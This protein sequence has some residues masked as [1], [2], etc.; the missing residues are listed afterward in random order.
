MSGD[1]YVGYK[2]GAPIAASTSDITLISDKVTLLDTDRLQ[3]RHT[4]REALHRR[5]NH[6]HRRRGGTLQLTANNFS[7]NFTDD[8]SSITVGSATTG[9]I[10]PGRSARKTT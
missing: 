7:S 5:H 8:F 10:T 6:R 2:A 3:S 4:D 9:K 1:V